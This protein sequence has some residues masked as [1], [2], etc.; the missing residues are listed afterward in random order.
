MSSSRQHFISAMMALSIGILYRLTPL[1]K[2][3]IGNF[4]KGQTVNSISQENIANVTQINVTE[5][6]ISALVAM[7]FPRDRAI[8]ALT[9]THNNLQAASNKLLE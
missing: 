5:E 4:L 8:D 3:R 1:N 7:G 6:N 2:L 9:K